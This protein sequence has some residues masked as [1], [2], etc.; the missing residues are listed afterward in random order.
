MRDG[1]WFFGYGSLV[2][3]DTHDYPDARPAE[4]KDWRRIWVETPVRAFCFLSARNAGEGSISGLI[5]RVPGGN[6][7]ALDE[8]ES[9]YTRQ[10]IGHSIVSGNVSEDIQIYSVPPQN[11]ANGTEPKP[12]L[13]SYLDVVLLGYRAVFG[14]EGAARFIATTDGWNR[15]VFDDRAHPLYPRHRQSSAQERLWIDTLLAGIRP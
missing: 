6:W 3:R 5:A 7:A 12:I 9:H 2:N 15:P 14:E 10:N 1:S 8:R 4:L 13:L 11:H